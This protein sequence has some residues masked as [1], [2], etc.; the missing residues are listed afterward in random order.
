MMLDYL[1]LKEQ[2]RL[3]T[4]YKNGANTR[5]FWSDASGS[6]L[7]TIY[8]TGGEHDYISAEGHT[9]ASIIDLRDGHFSSYGVGINGDTALENLAILWESKIEDAGRRGGINPS[10]TRANLRMQVQIHQVQALQVLNH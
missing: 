10:Y 2:R 6:I 3:A 8:D 7:A 1:A 4:S 9:K 5:H